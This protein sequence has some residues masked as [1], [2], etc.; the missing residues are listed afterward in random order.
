MKRIIVKAKRPI[1]AKTL[2]PT[3]RMQSQL[4]FDFAHDGYYT[5]DDIERVVDIAL[6]AVGCELTGMDIHSVDYSDYPEYNDKV[7]S[8]CSADFTWDARRGYSAKIINEVLDEE[9]AAIDYALVGIDF[10]S[11]EEEV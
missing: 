11:L 7:V 3:R 2:M 8:Q 4:S 6:D 5:D 9:L 1:S 10:T